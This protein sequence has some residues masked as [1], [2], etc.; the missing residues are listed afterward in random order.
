MKGFTTYLAGGILGLGLFTGM[1]CDSAPDP[2][3]LEPYETILKERMAMREE[4]IEILDSIVDED[5]ADSAI[6][7]VLE[8]R[9]RQKLKRAESEA[10]GPMPN[11]VKRYLW[12]NYSKQQADLK[13]RE[14]S[15]ARRAATV[16]G[17]ANFFEEAPF[18]NFKMV[19]KRR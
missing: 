7:P 3:V 17:S 16:P 13:K 14:D 10:L 18:Y 11:E 15:A 6:D 1:G 9:A 4:I 19:R 5:S 2:K 8:I 12:D